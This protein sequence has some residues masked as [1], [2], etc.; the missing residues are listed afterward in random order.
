MFTKWAKRALAY[1]VN[2]QIVPGISGLKG[3]FYVKDSGGNERVVDPSVGMPNA[4]MV[5]NN[6]TDGYA[7][8]TGT[9]PATEDDYCM[10]ALIT[11]GISL[12]ATPQRQSNFDAETRTYTI[13]YDFTINNTSSDDVTISELGMYC[14]FYRTTAIGADVN[15]YVGNNTNVLVEHTILEEPVTI[16][17]GESR[18]LRY[19]L[20]YAPTPEE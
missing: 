16:P 2:D 12:S 18:I 13:Y 10:E 14:N 17:A 3:T 9:T 11:S 15:H 5:T 1:R 8:G 7:F 4:R 6:T 19:Q 20:V